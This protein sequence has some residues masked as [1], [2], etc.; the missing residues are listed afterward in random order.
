MNN[1]EALWPNDEKNAW[2]PRTSNNCSHPEAHHRPHRAV[3][4]KVRFRAF[5]STLQCPRHVS[6][7]SRPNGVCPASSPKKPPAQNSG[8]G[9]GRGT[10]EGGSRSHGCRSIADT[11][12]KLHAIRP[13]Q[14]RWLRL[15][16][17][18]A[19]VIEYRRLNTPASARP[20]KRTMWVS[21]I[22]WAS[23]SLVRGPAWD[24]CARPGGRLSVPHQRVE[25]G[26]QAGS[27]CSPP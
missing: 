20:E 21:M 18:T 22:Q 23:L 1:L 3:S 12:G 26:R 16:A 2:A 8:R 27:R 4:L 19:Q 6:R 15:T 9:P 10:G 25:V 17:A 5:R 7:V 24:D 11:W 13:L 14:N